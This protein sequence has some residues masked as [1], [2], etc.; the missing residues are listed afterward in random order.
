MRET[1]GHS[2]RCGGVLITHFEQLR[3]VG[4]H[5]GIISIERT[6]YWEKLVNF[7]MELLLKS[8]CYIHNYSYEEIVDG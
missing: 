3:P 6:T 5:L 7:K 1:S 4:E 2:G 8:V